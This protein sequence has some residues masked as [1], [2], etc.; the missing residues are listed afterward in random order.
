MPLLHIELPAL[1]GIFFG[2][3]MQIAS[4]DLIPIDNY[5]DEH[6]PLTP[7]DPINQNFEAVGFESLYVLINLGSM[8]ILFILF[9]ALALA[10]IIMRVI[11]FR[12]PRAGS[13]Y[14]RKRLYWNSSIRFFRESYAIALMCALINMKA[15]TAATAGELASVTLSLVIVCLAIVVPIILLINIYRNFDQLG[16]HKVSKVIG[17]AYEHMKLKDN[18]KA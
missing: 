1:C 15:F 13:S 12:Y 10:E 14:L 5:V 4:F 8:L 17:S 7:R 3:L 11:P 6:T 18:D 16:A 2:F 9:P